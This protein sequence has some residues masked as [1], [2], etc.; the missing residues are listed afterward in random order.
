M[1]IYFDWGVEG[2]GVMVEE[3]GE[4][5]EGVMVEEDGEGERSHKW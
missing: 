5:K 4:G 2:E 1:I 3:D